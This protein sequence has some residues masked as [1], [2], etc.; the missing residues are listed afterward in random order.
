MFL[1]DLETT[2]C[3]DLNRYE[4]KFE[5]SMQQLLSENPQII[6]SNPDLAIPPYEN[7]IAIRE[8][9]TSRGPI[10]IVFITDNGDIVIVETKLL[11]N[12]E[13]HRTVVAQAIDYAKSFSEE[14][15]DLIK[16]KI[17]KRNIDYSIFDVNKSFE[18]ILDKNIKNG[19][20]QILIVGD[21]IHPNILGMVES[22]Q[23]APHLSFTVNTMSL[24]L[25]EVEKEKIVINPRIESK[26]LEIERSVISIEIINGNEI[27]IDSSTPDKERKG[28]KPK[29]TEEEFINNFERPEFIIS[30]RTLWDEIKKMN[31]SIDWGGVGFS[32]GYRANNKRISLIWVYDNKFNI[33]TRKMR[34]TYSNITDEQYNKYLN[35]LKESEYIYE[36]IV[37]P[38][39]SEVKY[40][41]IEVEDFEIAIRAI[42]WLMKELIY[43]EENSI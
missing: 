40:K 17:R 13:S 31:G 43:N 20:Y 14:T 26:T 29:I 22:I 4:I 41:N 39:K 2:E 33:L 18:S 19:N 36:N 5:D 38:N 42:V 32:G 12:S 27:R 37:V 3:N 15:V 34:N 23:S 25:F 6:L 9:S 10:D 28:N 35:K 7:V 24:N 16:K 1:Y 30:I 11:K 8:Y 21:E